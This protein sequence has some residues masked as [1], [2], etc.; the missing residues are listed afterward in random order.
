MRRARINLR[1]IT[2]G[3]GFVAAVGLVLAG[4]GGSGSNA[5][6]VERALAKERL[7]Q[8]VHCSSAGHGIYRCRFVEE[9]GVRAMKPQASCFVYR[10]HTLA[11]VGCP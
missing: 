7:A 1:T 3:I 10:Q 11:Q 9:T 4:C 8:D 5:G 6:A 2:E